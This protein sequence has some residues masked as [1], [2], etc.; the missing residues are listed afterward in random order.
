MGACGEGAR[1]LEALAR[2][3]PFSDEAIN[4]FPESSAP[5]RPKAMADVIARGRGARSRRR[6]EGPLRRA[7]S[8]QAR[9]FPG[10]DPSQVSSPEG[11]TADDLMPLGSVGRAR[12][13]VLHG[14]AG[15]GNYAEKRIMSGNGL[16][17]Q[18]IRSRQPR[19]F[20]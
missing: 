7:R 15:R 11:H 3:T 13:L 8:P 6:R 14:K 19:P 4:A 12:D 5:G 18:V 10:C 16:P 20:A 17:P 9:P 1:A 2:T